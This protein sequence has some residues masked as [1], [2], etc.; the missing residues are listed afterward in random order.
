MPQ[1][2]PTSLEL[3]G[4][5]EFVIERTFNGPPRIV[6]DAYTRP[7]L[8]QRWWAPRFL[9]DVMLDCQADVRPGGHYRYVMETRPGQKMA[10]SGTYVEVTPP[11]RLVFTQVYEPTAAGATPDDVAITITVTFEDRGGKT[12]LVSRTVCP[13]S[14]LRDTIIASGMEHGMRQAMDQLDELVASMA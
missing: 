4:D 8:V 3:R 7:E 14:E 12:H 2:N 10:F 1:T 9:G 6:F 11:T 5:R 13:T